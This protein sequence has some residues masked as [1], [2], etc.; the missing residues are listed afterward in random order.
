MKKTASI[1][2]GLLLS[3]HIALA[4]IQRV[5]NA[6][7]FVKDASL[8]PGSIATIFGTNLTNTT[9][10][11]SDPANPP[12][13]LGGVTVTVGGIASGLFYVSPTQVNFQIDSKVPVGTQPL[14]LQSQAGS[15]T[16]NLKI[17][18][19]AAPGIFAFSGAGTRDGAILN[20]VTF[21]RGP[22]SVTTNGQ[23]TFLALFTTGLDLS[24]PPT[25]T[26]GG[27]PVPVEF[28]GNAPCCS[29]LQQINVQLVQ[30]LAGAGR[31]EVAV[32]TKTRT[33]NVVEVVILPSLGQGPAAPQRENEARNREV[34]S[35][36][37]VPN[38]SIALLTDENDDVVRVI[39]V[40]QRK[41]TR[42]V[43]LPE[44]AEPV[45]IAVNAT[46]TL[47][48]VAERDL[49]RIAVIDLSNMNNIS[50]KN[51]L[52]VGGGPSAVAI[53]GNLALVANEDT[54]SV[55]VVQLPSGPVVNVAL[56]R[57]P[58]A[59][60][61]D[62]A[63]NRAF[64]TNQ[65]SGTITIVNFADK[66]KPVVVTPSINLGPDVRPAAIQ[67]LSGLGLAIVTEPSRGPDGRILLVNLA[68]GSF[69]SFASNPDRTGGSSDIALAGNNTIFL[70][71]QTG[72]SV[73][74]AT[75]AGTPPTLSLKTI[76]VDIGARALAV[77]TKDGD[78]VLLVTNEGSGTVV[79]VSLKT[80]EVIARINAVR[81]ENEGEDEH[82]DDRSDRDGASNMPRIT[83]ISPQSASPG[84]SFTFTVTGVNL[85]GATNVVFI[86]PATLPGGGNNGKGHDS[87]NGNQG[88]DR[89]NHG[90]GPFGTPDAA[91]NVSG[92]SVTTDGKSLTATVKI[93]A[94]PTRG[95]HVVRVMTPNG[96]TAFDRAPANTFTVK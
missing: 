5:V 7:S 40:A 78:G 16:V 96:E 2:I 9:A 36:A 21:A 74:M 66:D 70:A 46:G 68:A 30:Q 35:L 81:G 60:A 42:T 55:S 3:H 14:V 56:D 39:D 54:D 71:N 57:A 33:S 83:S 79:L 11:T 95:D 38:S 8:S 75:L 37:W 45:A 76:N 10:S 44:G 73:T 93:G 18:T 32:T 64:V 51:E 69:T 88:G 67:V 77:D 29:G 84:A 27:V 49:G 19:P 26:L 31:V 61:V 41:V 53:A 6:A 90:H 89:G 85:T 87:D 12:K 48:V 22:F 94:N 43:T 23:P 52:V 17:E 47:A 28:F 13:T 86:D 62:L 65:G 80:N 72:G 1:F 63:T 24:A 91:F 59:I 4:Q 34:A 25:V 82:R 58:R 50:V 20:A 15:L 92:I